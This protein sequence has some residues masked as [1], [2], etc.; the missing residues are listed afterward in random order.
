MNNLFTKYREI[1]HQG[2]IGLLT[3][4]NLLNNPRKTC[5]I[6]GKNKY[7]TLIQDEFFNKK[8]EPL[9]HIK[10]FISY[11]NAYRYIYFEDVKQSIS[12]EEEELLK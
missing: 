9:Y 10:Y 7:G 2:D 5:K 4:K 6:K 8:N 11:D 12:Y 3:R 1:L